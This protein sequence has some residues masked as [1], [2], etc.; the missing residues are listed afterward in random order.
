V[1]LA[2]LEIDDE[3]K[4]VEMSDFA[5]HEEYQGKGLASFLLALM[6]VRLLQLLQL[7]LLLV[8]IDWIPG[9]GQEARA[10]DGLYDRASRV[11]GDEQDLCQE[12]LHLRRHPGQQHPHLGP[13]P[14][15]EHL[16]ERSL[17]PI[18]VLVSHHWYG[19]TSVRA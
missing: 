17:R 6:D 7:L 18:D 19:T 13:H 12:R 4:N 11:G 16:V 15:D 10:E 1:A 14:V 2:G 5:T 9:G 8:L 3:N